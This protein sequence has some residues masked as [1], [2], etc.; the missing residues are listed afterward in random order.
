MKVRVFIEQSF[1]LDLRVNLGGSYV[2]MPQHSCTARTS[3]PPIS[4]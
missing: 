1:D 3:A 4:R 2:R